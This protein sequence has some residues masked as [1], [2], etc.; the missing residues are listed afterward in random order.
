[1]KILNT[2]LDHNHNGQAERKI[3]NPK[4]RNLVQ[5]TMG[6]TGSKSLNQPKISK[7]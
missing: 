3:Y 2:G 4:N 1:M 6:I 5:Q 7:M